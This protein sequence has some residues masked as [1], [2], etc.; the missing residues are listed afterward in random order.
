M[1]KGGKPSETDH[2]Q[3]F[4]AGALLAGMGK[5]GIDQ[6][7]G[8]MAGQKRAQTSGIDGFT[9]SHPYCLETETR[10]LQPLRG[11]RQASAPGPYPFFLNSNVAIQTLALVLEDC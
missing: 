5:G 10:T 9:P 8:K 1:G 11:T 2:R 3:P 7:G 4:A 6:S